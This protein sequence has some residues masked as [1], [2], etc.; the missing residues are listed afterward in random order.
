MSGNRKH[1][2]L[3]LKN[4]DLSNVN[5][6]FEVFLA[7]SGQRMY[8][9]DRDLLNL[10]Q[11]K[12]GLSPVVVETEASTGVLDVSVLQDKIYPDYDSTAALTLS[13]STTKVA[14]ALCT[15]RIQGDKTNALP[16]G[17]NFSGDTLSTSASEWNELTLLYI[18]DD[19]IRIVNRVFAQ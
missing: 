13:L 12:L 3:N 16:A 19:D 18:S 4:G 7:G 5:L 6:D 10:L 8:L 11:R 15:I 1:P 2:K 14:G 9:E 17:W